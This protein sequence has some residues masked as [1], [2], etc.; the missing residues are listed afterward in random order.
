MEKMDLERL[1]AA[2]PENEDLVQVWEEWGGTPYLQEVIEAL[3]RYEPEWNKERELGAW[4]AEFILDALEEGAGEW[5]HLT[6]EERRERLD[7]VVEE[8]YEDCRNGHQ[9]AR[10]NNARLRFA[11][12]EAAADALAEEDERVMFPKHLEDF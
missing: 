4:A 9:F 1:A 10:E 8:R 7:E 2:F 11:D 6:S 5:E 12:A 3:D